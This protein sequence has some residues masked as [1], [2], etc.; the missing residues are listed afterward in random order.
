MEIGKIF[1]IE[2]SLIFLPEKRWKIRL[3]LL[4]FLGPKERIQHH[5]R[6]RKRFLKCRLGPKECR[7][8]LENRRQK[9][10]KLIMFLISTE[11]IREHIFQEY[12]HP[13]EFYIKLKDIIQL[14]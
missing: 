6:K 9:L 11:R 4:V 12:P 1:L 13:Q 2:K 5:E 10:S 8:I 3:L 7:I 14:F